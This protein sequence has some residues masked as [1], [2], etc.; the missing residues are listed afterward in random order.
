MNPMELLKWLPKRSLSRWTGQVVGAKLP[1]PLARASIQSFAKHYR[2]DL[3]EAELPIEQYSSI[4]AFFTRKLKPGVRPLSTSSLVHPAD[5]RIT[6]SGRLKGGQ[7]IQAKGKTYDL[8]ELAGVPGIKVAYEGGTFFTYYLC[9]TDY[10]RVHSPVAGKIIRRSHVP[11]EL[12]PVNDWSTENI[13]RLFEVNER[14]TL[15]IETPKGRVL[16][17]FVGAT[18][19]GQI[20]LT[21]EPEFRSNQA[22]TGPDSRSY[23]PG[24]SVEKGEELGIFHMGSTVVLILDSQFQ[25]TDHDCAVLKNKTTRVRAQLLEAKR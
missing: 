13:E 15:E 2:I 17:V 11:G 21:H 7:L 12:W 22:L 14:V 8:D 5:A 19:V 6:Q 4:G 10:H 1:G 23:E 25:I 20:S 3:D 9:P 24:L 16:V 18:N